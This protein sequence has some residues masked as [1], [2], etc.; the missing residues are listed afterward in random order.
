MKSQR[1]FISFSSRNIDYSDAFVAALAQRIGRDSIFYSPHDIGAG[2]QYFDSIMKYLENC[3]AVILL[4]SANSVG[5]SLSGTPRSKHVTR[6]LKE[7]DDLNL[8][9][10][11]IDIDGVLKRGSYNTGPRYLIGSSQFIDGQLIPGEHSFSR[12]I[13]PLIGALSNKPTLPEI[14]VEERLR[15]ALQEGR[16][17]DATAI[18]RP[19]DIAKLNGDA[20]ILAIVADLRSHDSLGNL[21]LNEA[22][23]IIQEIGKAMQKQNCSPTGQSLGLYTAGVMCKEYFQKR[24][25]QCSLGSYPSLKERAR[26]LPRLSVANKKLVRGI[27]KDFRAFEGDWFFGS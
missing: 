25:I 21:P 13:E 24:V 10:Y 1:L 14:S 26:Q 22:E 3:D 4:A 17:E 27:S 5:C 15:E 7:S 9:I 2:E 18:A 12:V 6:E 23:Q 20:T 11:P 8:P 19:L 16:I